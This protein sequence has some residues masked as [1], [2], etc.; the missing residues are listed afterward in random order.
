MLGTP[1]RKGLINCLYNIFGGIY[2]ETGYMRLH[3]CIGAIYGDG[4]NTEEATRILQGLETNYYESTSVVLGLGS[5][6]YQYVTRDTYGTVCKATY[7]EIKGEAHPIFKD[8]KT[9]AWKKSHKG[10][11]KV[12]EDLSV[13]QNVGW[14]EE[15]RGELKTVFLD[16][17]TY[18]K[19]TLEEI[20]NRINGPV[21]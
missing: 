15:R 20:R 18:N 21:V 1:E 8:P 16:G 11:L 17:K 14:Q 13:N 19:R 7:C 10:L 9:G 2:N 3:P 4:I 12:N 5:Y 6:T